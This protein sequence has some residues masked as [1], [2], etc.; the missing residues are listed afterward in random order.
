MTMD[1]AHKRNNSIK[2]KERWAKAVYYAKILGLSKNDIY[3]HYLH[4]CEKY[5]DYLDS[6]KEDL[7]I[8]GCLSEI[9]HLIKFNQRKNEVLGIKEEFKEEPKLGVFKSREQRDPLD[10]LKIMLWAINEIGSIEKAKKVFN[11]AVLAMES[12]E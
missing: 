3:N 9:D 1:E 8:K 4:I 12:I 11:A 2:M 6:N 10:N 7:F 5:K